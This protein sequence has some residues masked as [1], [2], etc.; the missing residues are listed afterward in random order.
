[1]MSCFCYLFS[2]LVNFNFSP[3]SSLQSIR[4]PTRSLCQLRRIRTMMMM[5]R[6]AKEDPGPCLPSAPC[7]SCPPPTREWDGYTCMRTLLY[8]LYDA[9]GN[10]VFIGSQVSTGVS[11]HLHSTL[12][13]DVHPAGHRHEQYRPGR[14]RPCL[15]RIPPQQRKNFDTHSF[16]A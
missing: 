1:M 15:A 9:G 14:R 13:R 3:S 12:F 6:E 4:M 10:K 11:L 7:S 2:S 8:S 16:V 5:R